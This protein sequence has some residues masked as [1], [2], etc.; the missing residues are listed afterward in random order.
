MWSSYKILSILLLFH[1]IHFHA[2]SY[3]NLIRAFR[4]KFRFSA[5]TLCYL[6]C[7]ERTFFFVEKMNS[8]K[9][10][11]QTIISCVVFFSFY[12]FWSISVIII[13]SF[14]KHFSFTSVFFFFFWF[15]FMPVKW[16]CCRVSEFD[17]YFLYVCIR[18]FVY[19][20]KYFY[21]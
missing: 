13:F 11:T 4:I 12:L 19:M 16:F 10:L 18:M 14:I 20:W 8:C 7:W 5:M 15:V 3:E 1:S 9:Q 21:L 2:F 6:I 17:F